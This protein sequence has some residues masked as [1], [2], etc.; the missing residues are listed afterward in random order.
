MVHRILYITTQLISYFAE[1]RRH[2]KP[3]TAHQPVIVQHYENNIQKHNQ[4]PDNAKNN[5]KA[6]MNHSHRL[7]N[8]HIGILARQF[9]RQQVEIYVAFYEIMQPWREIL[10][11]H[12]RGLVFAKHV[13]HMVHLPDNRRHKEIT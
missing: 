11:R 6:A 1:P 12:I 9:L 7:V 5:I 8:K 10:Y 3:E 2:H 4:P 13:G